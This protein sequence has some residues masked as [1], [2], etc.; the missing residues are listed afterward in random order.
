MSQS[1]PTD[2]QANAYAESYVLYGDQS[3]AWR[4]AYPTSKCKP[5]NIHSKASNFHKLIKVQ[6][7]I[8][9]L[10]SKL[11][12][13]TEEEF[14]ITVSDLKKM[15]VMAAQGGLKQRTDAQQNKV[16][17]SISGAVAAIS[18][19]NRMDGNH[20]PTK[21]DLIVNPSDISPWGEV[22]ASVDKLND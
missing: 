16:P 22:K 11:T 17:V 5:E 1:N 10:R 9:E 12:K 21:T 19:I 13:Q 8:T 18:E 3:R 20:A 4:V 2:I 14:N 15:L 6:T 7:R